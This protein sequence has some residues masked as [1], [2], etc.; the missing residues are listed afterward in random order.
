MKLLCAL[1]FVFSVA[2]VAQPSVEMTPR[3][4]APIT[5]PSPAKPLEKLMEAAT[6][7]APF[8]NKNGHDV[9]DVGNN[10]LTVDALR[11]NAY[12]YRNLGER[13]DY[14]IVY[15][16]KIVFND[17]RTCTL[18]FSVKE[19][20][21]KE[22]PVKTTVADFFTPEGKLKEDYLEVK[23]S[24]ELTANKIVKSFADFIAN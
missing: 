9:Y 19:I 10:A 3:G 8:Y 4:F 12:F 20:Y 14:N 11:E 5:I 23:P 21:A 1:F 15:T 7:W 16:L 13:F 2:M 17:N 24:L 22:A 6:A 18:S